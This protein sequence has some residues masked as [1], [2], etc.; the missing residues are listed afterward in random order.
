M[1]S[2]FL[3]MI[4]VKKKI[5]LCIKGRYFFKKKTKAYFKEILSEYISYAFNENPEIYAST[6][7][8]WLNL[9]FPSYIETKMIQKTLINK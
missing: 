4:M 2:F 5:L 7:C 3:M 9:G 8:D 1:F 6:S